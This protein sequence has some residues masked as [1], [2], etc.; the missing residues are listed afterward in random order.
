M[1]LKIRDTVFYYK[2]HFALRYT[3][4]Y[5]IIGEK[6]WNI[7]ETK[8]KYKLVFGRELSL[9]NPETLNEKLQWLKL[10]ERDEYLTKCADKLL[11]RDIWKKYGEDGLVPLVYKTYNWREINEARLPDY[12][13]IIKCNT[14]CGNYVIVRDKEIADYRKIRNECKKWLTGNFYYKTQEYQYKNIKPCIMIEKL[15]LDKKG[16]I[17]NDYKLHYI[18]GELQFIYCSI[19]REGLDY[20]SIYSPDWKLLD[21]EWL[22]KSLHGK[23]SGSPIS[24]PATYERMVSIGSEIAKDFKYV[25]VDFYDVDGKLYYGEI[26]LEH[27]SGYDTFIPEKYDYI[28]GKKLNLKNE[29][30]IH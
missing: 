22:G 24:K 25:R 5:W 19:D 14:G 28:Y 18:N 3:L 29:N 7:F 23:K 12:P 26:T 17:P 2:L 21:F 20:R 15:L 30:N 27:G 8:R 4:P 9:N 13:C 11:S 6:N 16:K 1:A 10:N